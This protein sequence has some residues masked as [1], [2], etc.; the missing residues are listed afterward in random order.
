MLC[1]LHYLTNGDATVVTAKKREKAPFFAMSVCVRRYVRPLGRKK[2]RE[3]E[4]DKDDD[5]TPAK[6]FHK[7]VYFFPEKEGRSRDGMMV[8]KVGC[9]GAIFLDLKNSLLF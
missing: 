4:R 1:L 3:R 9:P 8:G 6:S 2:D 5:D 7:G